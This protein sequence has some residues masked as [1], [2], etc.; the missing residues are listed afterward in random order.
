MADETNSTSSYGSFPFLP[1]T[2]PTKYQYGF[3][4]QTG[5]SASQS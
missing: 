3:L 5:A 2:F 4:E 1:Q